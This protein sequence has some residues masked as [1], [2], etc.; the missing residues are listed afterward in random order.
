MT[1]LADFVSPL[2]FKVPSWLANSAWTEHGPFAMWLAGE[3][4]PRLVVELGSFGGYSLMAL[5]E[6]MATA[7]VQGRVVGIDTWQGDDHAGFYGDEIYRRLKTHAE[8][9]HAD[10]VELKRMLFSA[11]LGEVADASVDLLH[12]DGRH[13]YDDVKEDYLSWLPKLAPRGVALFHDTQVRNRDFGVWKFWAEISAGQPAFEFVHGNGL[14]VL[15]PKGMPLA[16]SVADLVSPETPAAVRADIRD[17][18][19]R[20]GAGIWSWKMAQSAL[21]KKARRNML[22]KSPLKFIATEVRAKLGA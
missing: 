12:V 5:A 18:Y 10:R 7:G 14:G 19:A 22:R 4:R 13:F 2:S 11:A 1:K 8:A 20:L 17:A 15:A 9:H 21:A 3:M 6:A 16:P